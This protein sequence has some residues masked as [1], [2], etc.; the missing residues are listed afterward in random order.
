MSGEPPSVAMQAGAVRHVAATA[1]A[2]LRPALEAAA[3]T[4]DYHAAHPAL[5]RAVAYFEKE[6]PG[7]VAAFVSDPNLKIAGL[8]MPYEGRDTHDGE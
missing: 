2:T 4:L 6:A 7:V 8:R 1:P 5:M 3:R